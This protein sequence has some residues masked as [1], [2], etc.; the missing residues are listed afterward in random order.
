MLGLLYDDVL[1]FFLKKEK[2]RKNP[3]RASRLVTMRGGRWIVMG[4]KPERG[5]GQGVGR[6]LVIWG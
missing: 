4:D 3:R 1:C 5:D 6:E 2:T